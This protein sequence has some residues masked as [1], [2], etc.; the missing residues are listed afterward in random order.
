M[1]LLYSKEFE[2]FKNICAVL[3]GHEAH[4]S[5]LEA[6]KGIIMRFDTDLKEFMV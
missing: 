3:L 6:Q 4:S 2:L 5:G 1:L